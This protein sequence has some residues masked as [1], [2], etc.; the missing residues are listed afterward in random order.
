MGYISDRIK[1]RKLP[2]FLGA[3]SAA[4]VLLIIMYC[5]GLN[6]M[7]LNVLM[8]LLGLLYS[9]QSIVFA[10]GREVSPEEAA[11]TAIAMTNMIVMIGAMLLQPLVGRLLDWSLVTRMAAASSKDIPIANMQ[12]L[13]SVGDYQFALAIVPL[14]V[15]IAALLTFFLRET[16]AQAEENART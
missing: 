16:Y 8:F 7:T 5:P 12:Q 6:L 13:Y 2:M 11:G 4:V 9:V 14:G 10:V 15:I 1:R 3:A